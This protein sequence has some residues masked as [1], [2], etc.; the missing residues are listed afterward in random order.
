MLMIS[1]VLTNHKR[2][3]NEDPSLHNPSG[4][5]LKDDTLHINAD[6]NPTSWLTRDSSEQGHEPYSSTVHPGSKAGIP[7]SSAFSNPTKASSGVIASEATTGVEKNVL[8]K[9]SYTK[10]TATYRQ[11]PVEFQMLQ[12]GVIDHEKQYHSANTSLRSTYH[13]R[14]ADEQRN[15]PIHTKDILAKHA[16]NRPSNSSVS[17]L[18]QFAPDGRLASKTFNRTL[19]VREAF[20]NGRLGEKE[21]VRN[22]KLIEDRRVLLTE[23]PKRDGIHE[24]E[25]RGE[26]F[27]HN[28][29][30]T[31]ASQVK[32]VGG[33]PP[34]GSFFRQGRSLPSMDRNHENLSH[35]S[36]SSHADIMKQALVV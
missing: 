1:E 26:G 33:L 25:L 17:G 19:P 2:S 18:A 12:G 6:T 22:K 27:Y 11:T 3:T 29:Q 32:S 9:E 24:K 30:G 13:L 28:N 5:S 14:N 20:L 10:P 23:G 7:V 4:Y 8:Q 34:R 35:I 21:G 36:R 16:E 31:D 15:V